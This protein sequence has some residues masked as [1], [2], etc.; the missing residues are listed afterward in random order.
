MNKDELKWMLSELNEKN[1]VIRGY[2]QLA[3]ECDHPKWAKRYLLS[4][5]KQTDQITSLTKL[6]TDLY[7]NSKDKDCD[8]VSG[9]SPALLDNLVSIKTENMKLH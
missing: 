8:W 6:I 2:T 9:N 7:I 4:I 3:L 5:I 1:A